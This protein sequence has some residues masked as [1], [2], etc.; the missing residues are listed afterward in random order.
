MQT[1]FFS[2][3]YSRL[4]KRHKHTSF[5]QERNLHD[6]IFTLVQAELRWKSS[7]TFCDLAHET[8]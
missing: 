6:I 5:L 4:N 8:R 3:Y 1:D 2:G 7:K